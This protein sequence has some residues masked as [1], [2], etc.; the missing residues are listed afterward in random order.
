MKKFSILNKIRENH[1]IAVVRGKEFD[2]TVRMIDSIIEG[3]IRNIE[4]TYTTP[5][6]LS[7]VW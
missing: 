2:D 1:L 3:G 4:I 6:D 7:S 5:R